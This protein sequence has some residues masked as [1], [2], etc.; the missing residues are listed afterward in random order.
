MW[1]A[2]T[3]HA[4]FYIQII[5][6]AK[7]LGGAGVFRTHYLLTFASVRTRTDWQVNH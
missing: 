5:Y 3:R 1:G 4:G 7:E 6:L 2:A